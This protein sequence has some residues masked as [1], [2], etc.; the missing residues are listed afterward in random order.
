[1]STNSVAILSLSKYMMM[2]MMHI[3]NTQHISLHK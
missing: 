2:M 1:M 3:W